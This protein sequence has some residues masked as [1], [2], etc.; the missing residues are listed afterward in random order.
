MGYTPPSQFTAKVHQKPKEAH[1]ELVRRLSK[2]TLAD[3]ADEFGVHRHTVQNWIARLIK[4]GYSD[5]RFESGRNPAG[6]R[7]A[8]LGTRQKSAS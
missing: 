8:T 6:V 4:L 7:P 3:V 1:A 2:A 5:P